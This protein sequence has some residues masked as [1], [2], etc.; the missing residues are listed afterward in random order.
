M[1]LIMREKKSDAKRSWMLE[2]DVFV[3][4]AQYSKVFV[5]LKKTDV[6]GLND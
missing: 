6:E 4:V 1:C 5:K 2:C 3:L